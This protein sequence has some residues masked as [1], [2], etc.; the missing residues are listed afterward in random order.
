MTVQPSPPAAPTAAT[1]TP[2]TTR[3]VSLRVRLTVAFGV[4]FVV[5]GA[6]LLAI[7]YVL[8]EQR[9]PAPLSSV[10]RST[11]GSG[12]VGVAG[13]LITLPDGEQVNP[14]NIAG[15]VAQRETEVRD[16]ALR[17]FLLQGTAALA[18]VSILAIGVTW[19][20]AGRALA[21]LQQITATARRIGSAPSAQGLH[22]RIG[23]QGPHDEV[24][25]LADTF[26]AMVARLDSAF[27]G[28]R[29]FVANASHELRTPLAINR[30][31]LEV[32]ASAPDAD[33]RLVHVAQTL[34]SVNARHERLIDGL[35]TLVESENGL[36]VSERVDL[37]EVAET[38]LAT[39]N[40]TGEGAAVRIEP[41]LVPAV[42]QGD[43]LLLERLVQNLVDNALRHNV[44]DGGWVRVTTETTADGVR[45]V[46]AN[47]GPVVPAYEVEGL[48]E[49]FRRLRRER[50]APDAPVHASGTAAAG[51]QRG[52][53]IGLSI[54]R[55]VATAHGGTVRATPLPE[56]GLA[57][58]VTLP[59]A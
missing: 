41:Y 21:P 3:R 19:L 10:I 35:L 11:L 12:D 26:D 38:V 9:T 36:E 16:E 49:P 7:T 51:R 55:A 39:R 54:V 29:R 8:V 28:Q 17:Q 52:A 20:L 43:G 31:V 1:P 14:G 13:P 53:G 24:R 58:T 18:G 4:L 34:L 30:T 32:A 27:G 47:S 22:E 33:P 44:T 6:V 2:A 57:I 56:G 42:V 25:E 50:S 59:P 37:A 48:F 23:L 45:L 15:F 46:I 40:L 5:T